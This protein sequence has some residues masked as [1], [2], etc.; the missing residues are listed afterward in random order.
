MEEVVECDVSGVVVEGDMFSSP[1]PSHSGALAR[2][3]PTPFT[4]VEDMP[5]ARLYNLFAKAG[6]RAACVT[7]ISA[8]TE[9]KEPFFEPFFEPLF[10]SGGDFR[11]LLSREQLIKAAR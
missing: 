1:L 3:D 10:V 11:G 9:N 6:E 5:A 7:S 4:V 2:Q 8:Q